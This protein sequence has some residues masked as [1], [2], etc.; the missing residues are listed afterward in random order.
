MDEGIPPKIACKLNAVADI[1]G[2]IA[3]SGQESRETPGSESLI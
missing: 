3:P 2:F 1:P